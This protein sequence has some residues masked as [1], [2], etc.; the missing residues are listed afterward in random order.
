MTAPIVAIKSK[1]EQATTMATN[2][3]DGQIRTGVYG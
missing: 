3:T 2:T 1:E